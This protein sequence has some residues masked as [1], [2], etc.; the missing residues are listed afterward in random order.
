LGKDFVKQ[1]RAYFASGMD[2]NRDR[3]AIQMNPALMTS[4]LAAPFKT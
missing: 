2:W 1:R 4:R 3:A